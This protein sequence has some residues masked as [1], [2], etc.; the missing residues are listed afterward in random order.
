[1]KMSLIKKV[2]G[3][4]ALSIAVASFAWANAAGTQY[5]RIVKSNGQ[6]PSASNVS[7]VAFVNGSD[8][9]I[10]T[11]NAFNSALGA[12]QGLVSR[13]NESLF[14]VNFSNF[15][16][17]QPGQSFNVVFTTNDGER[18]VLNGVVPAALTETPS[19]INLQRLALPTAAGNVQA[20]RTAEGVSLSWNAAAGLTYRVYRSS[21]ASGANNG[22]S[23]GIFERVAG[24]VTRGSFTDTTAV[25]SV[26]YWYV[27]IATDKN[28]VMSAHSTEV[29]A[30]VAPAI[31]QE[32]RLVK[33]SFKSGVVA[34]SMQLTK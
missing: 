7:F 8:A 16:A 33:P 23:N 28:G 19:E 30:P 32:N 2:L 17:A 21:L 29:F 27:V 13:G 15:A 20:Q 26:P 12:K 6:A 5:G 25:G 11:E 24:N 4:G 1:M 14:L 31:R 10:H 22:Q 3:L 34:G 9:V 18:G